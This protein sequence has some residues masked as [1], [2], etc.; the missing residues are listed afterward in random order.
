MRNS[1]DF[2]RCRHVRDTG[3]E[4][5]SGAAV[6]RGITEAR[7]TGWPLN[8]R[9]GGGPQ[10][11]SSQPTTSLMSSFRGMLCDVSYTIRRL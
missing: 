2:E 4:M 1:D 8:Y 6:P 3:L 9:D 7:R 10:Y 5:E 11:L